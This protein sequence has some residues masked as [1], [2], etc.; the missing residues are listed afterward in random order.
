MYS[1]ASAPTSAS[2]DN[3]KIPS[4]A[5][6]GITFSLNP[7]S[8][9]EQIIPFDS[10]PRNFVFLIL[11][12]SGKFAHVKVKITFC[13]CLIFGVQQKIYTVLISHN[14]IFVLYIWSYLSI[15]L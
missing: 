7:N 8:S 14:S 3:T 4:S 15:S 9:K 2:S 6:L 5:Y 11:I 12:F 10:V 1:E 13:P